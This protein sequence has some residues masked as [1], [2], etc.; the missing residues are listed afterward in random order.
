MLSCDN[1]TIEQN[2]IRNAMTHLVIYHFIDVYF[3]VFLFFSLAGLGSYTPSKMGNSY[4]LGNFT[5]NRN[6]ENKKS[7][8]NRTHQDKNASEYIEDT[9]LKPDTTSTTWSN[10]MGADILF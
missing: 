9:V 2:E 3:L 8:N 4:Q 6:V 10:E 1:N 7:E 5:N